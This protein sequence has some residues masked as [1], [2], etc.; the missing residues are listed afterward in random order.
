MEYDKQT[1]MLARG[2]YRD[3]ADYISANRIAYNRFLKQKSG[4]IVMSPHE[5][6]EL[7]NEEPES[8]QPL[9]C[10]GIPE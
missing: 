7:S 4:A 1:K 10:R 5:Q 6:K 8:V 9:R 2:I 3:I